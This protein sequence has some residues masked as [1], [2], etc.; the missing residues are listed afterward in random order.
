MRGVHR[1]RPTLL[2]DALLHVNGPIQFVSRKAP[3]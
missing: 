2:D 3:R 1:S